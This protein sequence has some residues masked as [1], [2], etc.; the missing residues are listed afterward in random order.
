M[1]L[2]KTD[3]FKP[4]LF[5]GLGGN[6]GKTVNLLAAKLRRHPHWD[7]I[8]TMTHFVA[9]DT[10]KDDLDKQK[11]IAP[12][13]RFLV[14]AFDRRAYV[15]RKRGQGE[16]P[17]DPL[18]T[19]W[20]H[21]DY[22]F[23]G[24]Q[25]AGAGQ[26]RVES[27]LG[28]YY[29]LEDDARAGIRRKIVDLLHQA[30][31][32]D[33]P[34]RDSED[35]VIQVI[36]YASVAGGTGSGGFLPMAYLLRQII[37][38][39]GWGRPN[40]VGVLSLP[41]TFLDKVKPQLHP[42]IMANGYAALKELEFLTRQLGYEGGPDEI[43]FHYDPGARSRERQ[44]VHD[45]PFSLVY[46]VDRPAEVSIDR[47]ENAVAD[48]SFLQIF[49]PLLGAQA[50]EYDNYD[51]HQKS[52]ALGHFAVNYAAFGTAVLH[53]PRRD[54]VRYAGLRY[55]ARALREYLCFGGDDPQFRVPYG[56][57]SFERLDQVQKDRIVD[58]RFEA[59][60]ASRANLEEQA[61]EK[62]VFSAIWAQ[63]G[64]QGKALGPAFL[65]R[66]QGIYGRLDELVAIPDIE[67]QAINPGN[68]SMARSLAVL[69]KE[70]AESRTRVRGFLEAQL[71]ELR[72]GRLFGGFFKDLEVN[73]I[74][75]RLFLIRL[76]RR[77][78]VMP[79]EDESEGEFL[80]A[81]N[82]RV[83]LDSSVVQDEIA[84]LEAELARTASQGL[85]KRF[86]DAENKDFQAAKT[87]A[88]RRYDA[89]AQDHREDL[90]RYFWRAFEAEL[91]LV[92]GALLSSYRKV[93]EIAD[94]QARLAE[95]ECEQFRRDP[96]TNPESDVAQYYLDAEALRDDRRQERLWHLFYLHHLDKSSYLDTTA[97]FGAV[98]GAFAPARDPDGRLRSRDAGEIVRAVRADLAGLAVQVYTQALVDLR[99]DLGSA[100]ELE[101]RYVAL[102]DRG[103]D[104][105]ALRSAG[106]LDQ[107]VSAV[108]AD[109]VARGVEDRLKR[110]AA[111]CALLAHIDPTRR[112]DPTV[113]PAVVLYAGLA[114][115][116]LTDERGSLGAA[117][118]GVVGG[119]T[120]VD[121]WDD[122]DALVLYRALL[123]IP[124]YWFKNVEA[125]LGPS[126]RAVR[127]RPGRSYPLHIESAWETSAAN[128]GLPDLDPMELKRRR[129][130]DA[131][132]AA[133]RKSRD[134]RSDRVKAFVQAWLGGS[135]A[136]D[137]EQMVWVYAGTKG[138]LG[139]ERGQ[140]FAAFE[141]LDPTLR[142]D[143]EEEA[144]G[145]LRQRRADARGREALR[146][147]VRA[148]L[149][150][151]KAAFARALADRNDSEKGF[152][153]E[154]RASLE[155]L[156]GELGS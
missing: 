153:G 150:R 100:L 114:P 30:T 2:L 25:G 97:I 88:V 78:F 86:V 136:E 64:G 108:P 44:V 28:L 61:D 154:V 34:W 57:G 127:D 137:G 60:V 36:M 50:G 33:N 146:E 103:V 71:T 38:D 40:L 102:L 52:L 24:A 152:L 7:R 62:G 145:V 58:E 42:D 46:L 117:V 96:G 104:F 84:R 134:A 47:Y 65:Q 113:T 105:H 116:F 120:F 31:G 41:T 48:A 87:R 72:T 74:A 43:E 110:L 155:A 101:Q 51:K 133:A 14:S 147:E 32:R 122:P 27:R 143:L 37:D 39:F 75:Q 125:Q 4:T 6:G 77:A 63:T 118:K 15:S 12:D 98:T 123:G 1:G 56:E 9:I 5:V 131:V 148:M 66:L 106:R 17:E 144:R 126:Y 68:P 16:L 76:L 80:R 119:V 132:E 95:A 45:R 135:V 99:L 139:R 10:N 149:G 85:L 3:K 121:G 29:N 138:P 18:V 59:Y 35:R 67:R 70:Y 129:E 94:E 130:Q 92:T 21:P 112:D 81:E 8:R 79:F 22:Q 20:V 49:S 55:V 107:E 53:L 91:R 19:Q 140:A 83:D 82:V 115:R 13:A 69:R 111:D 151:T 93:A 90:R 142:G 11:N 54:V 23:R 128:Q 109:A 141:S 26:I 73:P 89:L 156:E 124:I